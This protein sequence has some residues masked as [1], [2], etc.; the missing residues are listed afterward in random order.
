M[1]VNLPS[2]G[3]TRLAPRAVQREVSAQY[4][5]REGVAL[6]VSCDEE[7]TVEEGSTYQCEGT[8]ADGDDVPITITI[9]SSDGDYTWSQD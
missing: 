1:V 6:D 7:M 4:E 9:T 5:Q 3:T 2:F 8:T